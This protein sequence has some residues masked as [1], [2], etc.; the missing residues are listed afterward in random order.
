MKYTTKLEREIDYTSTS[1]ALSELSSVLV[2]IEHS[3]NDEVK[4]HKY[5]AYAKELQEGIRLIEEE[6]KRQ[7]S[8]IHPFKNIEL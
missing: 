7:V 8:S 1:I 3:R 6:L 4:F 2:L 5:M